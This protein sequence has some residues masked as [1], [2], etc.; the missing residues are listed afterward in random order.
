MN[1][2]GPMRSY[3]VWAVVTAAMVSACAQRMTR[4][5]GGDVAVDTRS[6]TGGTWDSQ[7]RGMNGWERVRGSAFAQP[8]D[9]GTRVA[10]TIERGFAGSNYGWDVREGTCAAPGRVVGDTTIYPTLFIGEDERD[11]K[12]AD[13]VLPLERGKSYI[14]NIYATAVERAT[15]IACGALNLTTT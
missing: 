14:V 1:R 4:E 10:V 11:S 3:M 8:K 2:E 13:I 15:T 9:N 5:S 12:V 6:G 7:L